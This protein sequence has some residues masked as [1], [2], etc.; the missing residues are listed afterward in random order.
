M[1]HEKNPIIDAILANST[2]SP[3]EAVKRFEAIR[4]LRRKKAGETFTVPK[5]FEPLVKQA[6]EEKARREQGK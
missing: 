3:E 5:A 4:E 1:Q 2:L 6:L